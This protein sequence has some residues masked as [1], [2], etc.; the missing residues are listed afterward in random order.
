MF[1]FHMFQILN[2]FCLG[3]YPNISPFKRTFAFDY[4]T[5]NHQKGVNVSGGPPISLGMS[6]VLDTLK[7]LIFLIALF[8]KYDRLSF[9]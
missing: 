4:F 5:V 6:G 7:L 9:S 8:S 3:I 2:L 1:D